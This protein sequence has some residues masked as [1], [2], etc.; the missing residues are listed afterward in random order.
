MEA[1][2]VVLNRIVKKA[3]KVKPINV[4]H[5]AEEND[6]MNRIVIEVQ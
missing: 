4:K 1:E 2:N 5:M 3:Q 6:V